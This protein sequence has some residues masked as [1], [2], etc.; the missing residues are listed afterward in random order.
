MNLWEELN[1]LGRSIACALCAVIVIAIA[2]ALFRLSPPETYVYEPE[3]AAATDAL[4][5]SPVVLAAHLKSPDPVK[6]IY[7]SACIAGI[8]KYR[9]QMIQLTKGTD[10]NSMIVDLKDYTGT[11]S[12]DLPG[13]SAPKGKGCRVSDLPTFV[14]ELHKNGLYAI[15][16]VTVFQDPLYSKNHPDLAV[17]SASNPGKPWTDRKGLA[18]IDPNSMG[19]WDHIVSIAKAAYSIG[20]DEI[21]FDYIRFPSDGDMTDAVFA[22]PPGLKKAD[23]I[24]N[25]FQHLHSELAPLGIKTSADLF[26][27]TTVNKDDLG[28][29]QILENALPYFDYVMPMDYP[30]HFING[31]LGY[32][33]PATKPYEVIKMTMTSAVERTIAA[34]SS[35]D[36]L[37]PWLQA[38]DLGADYTPEM[39]RAQ[40]RGV[41]DSGLKGWV[42][43]DA[44]NRYTREQLRG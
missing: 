17:Q 25:F 34:S 38:F 27:Q 10:V 33:N 37:R 4:P 35:I 8:A 32:D 21:N 41:E 5:A 39:V 19:Y 16:R 31:F 28:I 13:V 23:V 11:L 12:Y 29:G 30:S 2:A 6:G 9:D 20:F 36:K 3:T 22:T 43:W 14:G 44:A 15:A 40:I 26:G 7:M 24:A 18:Y 42:L 1:L